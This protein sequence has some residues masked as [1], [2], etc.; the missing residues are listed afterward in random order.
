MNTSS[1]DDEPSRQ[2]PLLLSRIEWTPQEIL[3][4]EIPVLEALV[5]LGILIP[6]SSQ[7]WSGSEGIQIRS[8]EMEEL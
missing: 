2:R 8:D 3:S 4:I 1:I 5:S 6:I 7:E